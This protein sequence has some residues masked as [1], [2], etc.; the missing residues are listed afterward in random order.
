MPFLFLSPSVKLYQSCLPIVRGKGDFCNHGRRVDVKMLASSIP[1]DAPSVSRSSRTTC[2]DQV[3]S[4]DMRRKRPVVPACC[5]FNFSA[6]GRGGGSPW[7]ACKMNDS[8]S[9]ITGW[10][11]YHRADICVVTDHSAIASTKIREQSLSRWHAKGC[12]V[13]VGVFFRI[14]A[15]RI[16]LSRCRSRRLGEF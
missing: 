2:G 11:E 14:L 7:T 13:V 9:F 12:S 3:G 4:R 10:V 1:S 6:D 8:E 16:W 15:P 5:S